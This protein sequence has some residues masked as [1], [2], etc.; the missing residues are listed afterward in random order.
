LA[1]EIAVHTQLA[2][3]TVLADILPSVQQRPFS[4]ILD[5]ADK[6]RPLL[7]SPVDQQITP[8]LIYTYRPLSDA[9]LARYIAF[10][11]SSV[12][13]HY[14][15]SMFNGIKLAVMDASIRFGAAMADL[16]WGRKQLAGPSS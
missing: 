14:Y 15:R 16:Q 1:L 5:E 4:E 6:N 8:F 3:T 10:A 9:E 7:E 12:G 11:R 13:A 2:V